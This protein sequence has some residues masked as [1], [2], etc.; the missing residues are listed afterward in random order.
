MDRKQE[1]ETT[2]KRL[3]FHEVD[4][5]SWPDFARLF[6]ERGG[7]KNCWCMVWRATPEEAKQRSGADRRAQIQVRVNESIPIGLLGYLDD[8]PVA[9]C[10]IAPRETYRDLGGPPVATD[11]E[12][13]WSLVCFFIKRQLRGEG[14][15]RQLIE[16]AIAHAKK[17]G[18]NIIEAYPVDRD[19]PS[20]RF[21][22]FLDMFDAAGFEQ[23]GRAGQRRHIM[24]LTV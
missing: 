3:R 12:R 5:G 22:G 1:T 19:S 6:E 2:P 15:S 4:S 9:W 14:V 7:P 11:Q 17:H 24:R 18:A 16:A 23:I 10:S 8:E 13:I 20:Y 21:M